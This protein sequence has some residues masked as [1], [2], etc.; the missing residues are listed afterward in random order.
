MIKK[1]VLTGLIGTGLVFGLTFPASA[2]EVGGGTIVDETTDVGHTEI[3]GEVSIDSRQQVSIGTLRGTWTYGL[4]GAPGAGTVWST[5]TGSSRNDSSR[6]QG[7]GTV[8]NGAGHE[9]TGGW[10]APGISSRGAIRRTLAGP[11]STFWNLRRP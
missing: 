4:T 7:R 5:V 10:R 1:L 6:A 3:Q 9:H 8:R 2:S 11:N